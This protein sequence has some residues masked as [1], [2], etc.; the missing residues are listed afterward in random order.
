MPSATSAI[1]QRRGEHVAL[2]DARRGRSAACRRPTRGPTLSTASGDRSIGGAF[3]MPHCVHRGRERVAELVAE[4]GE[5]R[6]AR[7]DEALAAACRRRISPPKLKSRVGHAG[8][9]EAVGEGELGVG[10]G[11]SRS[12]APTCV[13]T[14]L[15]VEPGGVDLAVGALQRGLVVGVAV[16]RVERALHE[17]RVVHRERRSGRRWGSSTSPRPRRSARR[18]RPPNPFW[19]PSASFA[20]CWADLLSDS[21]T[22]LVSALPLSTLPRLLSC[23]LVSWPVSDVVVRLLDAGAAHQVDERLVAGD[24]REQSPLRVAAEVLEVAGGRGRSR[25][26]SGRRR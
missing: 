23:K 19:P 26:R 11:E 20:V 21:T 7:V 2:A 8:D 18:A 12:R 22:L 14:T 9:L 15:N 10:G 4:L 5:R 13:V 24:V 17:L 25:R 16:D 6:V 3:S 1:S